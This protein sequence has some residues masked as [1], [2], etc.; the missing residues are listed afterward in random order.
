MKETFVIWIAFINLSLKILINPT[1]KVKI[2]FLLVKNITIFIKYLN[3][4]H[5]FSKNMAIKFPEYFAL[6]KYLQNLEPDKQPPYS[7][8][9]SL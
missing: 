7:L 3:F 2:V 9:Y 6:K 1:W 8:I 4:L 5:I